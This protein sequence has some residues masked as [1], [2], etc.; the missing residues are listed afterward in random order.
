MK[1]IIYK[2]RRENS[3]EKKGNKTAEEFGF[4]EIQARAKRPLRDAAAINATRWKIFET[5]QRHGLPIEIGTGGRTKFNRTRLGLPKTHWLDAACVGASTPEHISIKCEGV[6]EIRAMGHGKHQRV[7]TDKYGF[8]KTHRA[9]AKT[10]MG[11]Q[12]GDIVRANIPKGVHAGTHRG[13]IVIRQQPSFAFQG[14]SVHP[15]YLTTIHKA[16]GYAYSTKR[17][18][19]EALR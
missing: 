13:R 3:N 12:T 15:K 18:D 2:P 10:F 19:L 6:L 17:V 16:D 7:I 8:P 11:F 9:R 5:L 4:P 1:I 14:F